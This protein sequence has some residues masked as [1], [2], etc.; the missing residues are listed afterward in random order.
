MAS[1]SVVIPEEEEREEEQEEEQKEEWR[2]N[3]WDQLEV[4]PLTVGRGR[5]SVPVVS[6][7]EHVEGQIRNVVAL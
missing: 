7:E 3:I 1:I 5:V 6:P 4:A 2:R